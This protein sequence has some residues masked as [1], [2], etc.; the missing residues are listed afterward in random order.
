VPRNPQAGED[1]RDIADAYSDSYRRIVAVIRK[2]PRG[3]V[4]TYGQ[5]A[6]AANLGRAARLVGYALHVVWRTVPWQ[7]VLGMRGKGIAHV[8]IKD[9]LFGTEQ[10]LRL[11]KEGVRFSKSGGVS[12][13][14]FGFRPKQRAT[15][16]AP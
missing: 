6:E 1:N 16:R 14:E 4:M 13:A 8:S 12:L 5:V 11:E 10:R 9:P 15:R 3:K 2:I 7:R